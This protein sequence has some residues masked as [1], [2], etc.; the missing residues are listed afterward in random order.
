M[1]SGI[2]KFVI[3]ANSALSKTECETI[4][5]HIEKLQFNIYLQGEIQSQVRRI[6][7]EIQSSI[8]AGMPE[9]NIHIKLGHMI[10]IHRDRVK[11]NYWHL[12]LLESILKHYQQ[13]MQAQIM[14]K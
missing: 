4:Q 6:F 8:L 9:A 12:I 2:L 10:S 13:F 11:K 1:Q 14:I 3:Q 7:D 5:F